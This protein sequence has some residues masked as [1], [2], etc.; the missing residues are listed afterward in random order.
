L[1]FKCLFPPGMDLKKKK[2]TNKT[3]KAYMEFQCVE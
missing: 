2:R 3:V 1:G